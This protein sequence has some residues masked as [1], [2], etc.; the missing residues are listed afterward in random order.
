[1]ESL[2]T[3]NMNIKYNISRANSINNYAITDFCNNIDE[4]DEHMA[5][6]IEMFNEE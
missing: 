5:E 2:S 1:M 6:Q 3:K 4:C